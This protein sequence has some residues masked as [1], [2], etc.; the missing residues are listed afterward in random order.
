MLTAQ[1]VAR[2]DFDQIRDQINQEIFE[3]VHAE[4]EKYDLP[5]SFGGMG[6][7]Y[8]GLNKLTD[9]DIATTGALSYLVMFT[10]VAVLLRSLLAVGITLVVVILTT[11]ISL[12]T[13]GFFGNQVNLLTMILPT[14]F[15][16][17]SIADCVHALTHYRSELREEGDHAVI[18]KRSL[19]Y[20]AIPCLFTTLT[21]GFGFGSL[22]TAEMEVIH[23][24]GIYAALEVVVAYV[25]TFVTVPFFLTFFSSSH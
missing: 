20:I 1:L 22:Y 7:M 6:V 11:L 25:V 23:D 12:G 21:T 10:L 24:L 19:G 3:I 5:V 9:A 17:L 2:R 4:T 13:F 15:V 14:L 18:M 8:T 16:I